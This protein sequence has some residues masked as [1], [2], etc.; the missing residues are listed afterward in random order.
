MISGVGA[1]RKGGPHD[2]TGF[3]GTLLSL[4][5]LRLLGWRPRT[6]IPNPKLNAAILRFQRLHNLKPNPPINGPSI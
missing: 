1:M 5:G 6:S 4:G 3:S 2:V